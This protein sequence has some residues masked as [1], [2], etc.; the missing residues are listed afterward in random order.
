MVSSPR[1]IP[2]GLGVA[3]LL[4][5]AC[6]SVDAPTSP[7][8]GTSTA[9]LTPAPNESGSAAGSLVRSSAAGEPDVIASQAVRL[10]ESAYRIISRTPI[11]AEGISQ[12]IR[13]LTADGEVLVSRGPAEDSLTLLQQEFVLIQPDGDEVNFGATP[14][15]SPASQIV[16]ASFNERY[17]VW[18][19]TPST[20]LSVK[21][22]VLYAYDRGQR[23]VTILARSSAKDGDRDGLTPLSPPGFSGPVVAGDH[24]YWAEAVGTRTGQASSDI[25]GCQITACT[26]EVVFAGAAFPAV[27]D[28]TLYGIATAR[29]AGETTADEQPGTMTILAT[30]VGA[31]EPRNVATV[32]LAFSQS[33]TGLAANGDALL[34]LINDP[35]GRP[36][37]TLWDRGSS[38]VTT[39]QGD[40]STGF[41]Y[42]VL[43][44][45]YAAWG[46]GSGTSDFANFLLTRS[47]S[48]YTLGSVGSLYG[49]DGAGSYVSWRDRIRGRASLDRT[50]IETIL[51]ELT[52]R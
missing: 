10:P 24:V 16:G 39:M 7:S 36:R 29:F 22:W 35:R 44:D 47:N 28:E 1:V 46:E 5:G 4:I 2:F 27:A 23:Q 51:A 42:P 45:A 49:A 13:A 15:P 33:P 43:T 8:G 25:V 40:S 9:S 17:V 14:A 50:N 31:I 26:P 48:L 37:A 41:N 6:S 52:L 30:P 3:A 12:G 18:E 19:E 34:W 32:D 20:E 11:V 21:P 38:S